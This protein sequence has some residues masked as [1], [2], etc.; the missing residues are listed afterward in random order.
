MTALHCLSGGGVFSV[1]SDQ[2]T[3]LHLLFE[4]RVFSTFRVTSASLSIDCS[5]SCLGW[6]FCVCFMLLMLMQLW[7]SQSREK[8]IARS[9]CASST[10]LISLFRLTALLSL[11][12][13]SK[14]TG[15]N[16][17]R[18]KTLN[19]AWKGLGLQQHRSECM[20]STECE[21]WRKYCV[22]GNKLLTVSRFT[23]QFTYFIHSSAVCASEW[24]STMYIVGGLPLLLCAISEITTALA[25][26]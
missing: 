22:C 17:Y 23:L 12:S 25:G 13:F 7:P 14:S 19:C 11:L 24:A 6:L 5:R 26:C 1:W 20:H 2:C 9:H 3:A 21:L 18:D 16:H 4:R 15:F 8:F 10:H